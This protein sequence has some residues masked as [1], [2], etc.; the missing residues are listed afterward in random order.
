MVCDKEK[1]LA[2]RNQLKSCMG[3]LWENFS[4][5]SQELSPEQ[6]QSLQHYGPV[7]RPPTQLPAPPILP[8]APPTL[9]SAPPTLPQPR[10][11]PRP[12]CPQPR[13]SCSAPRPSP[14]HPAPSPAHPAPSPAHPAPSPA[15]RASSP[16]LDLPANPDSP[17][18]EEPTESSST[19]WGPGDRANGLLEAGPYQAPAHQE[20]E[21]PIEPC[22]VTV[23][24][25]FCREMTN[26]CTTAEQPRRDCAL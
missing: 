20:A 21:P 9:P 23:T 1:L 13:P 3:E 16:A 18:P 6:V 22:S 10:P 11:A 5:L 17:T 4:C 25:D 2:E 14:T 8:S 26:K 7:Q 15:H 19:Q 24:V 12:S